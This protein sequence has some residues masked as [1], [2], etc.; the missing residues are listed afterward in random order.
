M[1]L[2]SSIS[3]EYGID[4]QNIAQ[5]TERL[6]RIDDSINQY[7][8]KKSSMN[9]ETLTTWNEVYKIANEKKILSITPIY[10]TRSSMFYV[11]FN[12]SIY[13]LS[14]WITGQ[15]VNIEKAYR[16]LGQVHHTTKQAQ[17]IKRE[18]IKQDFLNFKMNCEKSERKLLSYVEQFEQ[19]RYMSPLELQVCT[20]YRDL[21][22][23]FKIIQ[24]KIYELINDDKEDVEWNICLCHGNI[25]LSHFLQGTRT[26]IINWESAIF[27]NATID[28]L[29]LY[30]SEIKYYDSPIDEFIDHFNHYME[31][32]KLTK[33]ELTFLSIHLL[34]PLKYLNELDKYVQQTSNDS[35]LMQSKRME[36]LHRQLVFAL[37][38][39]DHLQREAF[40][41]SD[42]YGDEDIN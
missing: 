15:K 14:P 34:N 26:Y 31:E 4:P 32:N 35:I 19:R 13:Y 24:D 2:I 20:H 23:L 11:N 29:D 3:T 30:N 39:V 28:L 5:I 18:T 16:C 7:A 9:A 10:L 42:D 33:D 25:K 8:L 12:D 17:K 37:K 41:L 40:S 38:F 1:N 6:Y 21:D 22:I 36:Q 27:Q